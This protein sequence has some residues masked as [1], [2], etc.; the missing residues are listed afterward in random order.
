MTG[1][2]RLVASFSANTSMMRLFKTV[3]LSG[4]FQSEYISRVSV[5][6][7]AVPNGLV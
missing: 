2:L 7:T 5:K 1:L 3:W 6:V 4:V